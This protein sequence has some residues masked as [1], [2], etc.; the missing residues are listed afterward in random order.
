MDKASDFESGDCGFKSHRS[1]LRNNYTLL[2]FIKSGN[3]AQQP[4]LYSL[5]PNKVVFTIY[6]DTWISP[7]N[8]NLTSKNKNQ[9]KLLCG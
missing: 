6:R 3:M 1:C 7:T 5:N 2:Q 9:H 8:D 4:S